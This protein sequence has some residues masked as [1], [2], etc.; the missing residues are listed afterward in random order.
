MADEPDTITVSGT[1][2]AEIAATAADVVVAVRGSAAFGPDQ[3]VVQAREVTALGQALEPLGVTAAS[4]ELLSVRTESTAGRFTRGSAATYRLRVRAG[5]LEQLPGILDVVAAHRAASIEAIEWR[6]PEQA[7]R[8]AALTEAI[9]GAQE[10]GAAV[11]QALGVELRAVHRFTEQ[12]YDEDHA[13]T[14]RMALAAPASAVE[15][16][17]SLGLDIV[18]RKR[19]RAR[20]ELT[21]RTQ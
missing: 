10:A 2:A 5:S 18:H 15:P 19:V 8:T 7:G 14:P 13:P 20:V 6:Y 16:G 21:Y 9:A 12:T 17:P 11:A 4:I 3:S 1:A